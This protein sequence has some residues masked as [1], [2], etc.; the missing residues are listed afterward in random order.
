M[1]A[2]NVQFR[3][4]SHKLRFTVLA[5]VFT[6]ILG[7]AV[8]GQGRDSSRYGPFRTDPANGAPKHAYSPFA[9]IDDPPPRPL[10]PNRD[11]LPNEVVV[12]LSSDVRVAKA[13]RTTKQQITLF[14]DDTALN[15]ALERIGTE[16]IEPVFQRT[17]MA[18]KRHNVPG[19]EEGPDL[20]RW[21][22]AKC[23]VKTMEAVEILKENQA[24]KNAEPNFIRRPSGGDT[25]T[26]IDVPD[27]TAA[28][29]SVDSAAELPAEG[30]DPL[31]NKSWHLNAV[32]AP[33]AW[34]YLEG[35]GLPAG[36]SR[37]I[38]V[39][40]IDTGVDY[41][42]QDLAANLWV[43]S[44]EVPNNS[45]DDDGNGFVDDVHGVN[46]VS[47]D[48]NH[49]GDPMD[50]HGHG[51]HVAGIVAA[52]AGNG[53]GGVGVAYNTQ[54]M[55]IKAAQ[56]SG[57][58]STSDI[59]E[60]I[61]YAVAQGADIINMSFGGYGRSQIE[62]DALAVAF[63]HAVLVASAGND[64]NVN[65]PCPLGVDFYPAAYNW[66]L[67]VMASTES[68]G[69]AGFSNYDCT[70]HDAHEYELM[71]PGIDIWSTLPDN[72]YAA[73]DGTSMSAPIVSGIAALLR[74]KFD[75]KDMYSSRF[76]MGQVAANTAGGIGG[77]ADADAALTVMP[78]PEISYLRH[79]LF[80]TAE[81]SDVNDDDGIVDAGETVDLAVVIRN[82]WGKAD[83]VEVSLSAEA[84]GAVDDDPFVT[85][86][87]SAV[88]YGATGS[89]NEDDNGLIYDEG[90]A[91]TGVRH[92][93]TF[94]VSPDCPNDH[95]IPFKITM[96]CDNGYDESDPNNPYTFTSR[97]NL[98]VQR[99]K[100]LPRVISE[101][102][103]LTKDYY[104]IVAGQVLI[105]T[106]ITLTI[107]EGTQVQWG[108]PTPQDPYATSTAPVLQVEGTLLIEGTYG[109][110]VEL[111][112]SH[113]LGGRTWIRT[114]SSGT[115]KVKYT[116]IR[117]PNVGTGAGYDPASSLEH[118][119]FDWDGSCWVIASDSMTKSIVSKVQG[120]G[121]GNY[122]FQPNNMETCLLDSNHSMSLS[123]GLNKVTD[124][125]FLQDNQNNVPSSW[126]LQ[127]YEGTEELAVKNTPHKNNAFL[128]KYWDPNINHWMRF[129]LR[130][131]Q[132]RDRYFGI[133]YNYWGTTSKLLIDASI[134]DFN[135][136][137]NYPHVIYQPILT[138][139]AES[140]YPF[141]VD[142]A[143]STDGQSSMSALNG[144]TP[145]VGAEPV[146]F[147][148]TFN[149]DMDTNI[150][151]QVS[152]GPDVPETDYTV[153]P[154]DGG[155]QDPRTWAGTFNISAV[156]GDGY[157]LMRVA[158]AV[159][160]DDPWLVTGDDTERFRFEIITS[161]TEAMNL[162][163]ASAEGRVELSWFQ[164]DFDLLAGFNLYRSSQENGGYSRLNNT[165]IPAQQKSYVDRN[166][167]P[168][169]TYYYKFTVVKS[170]M[171]E[172]DFSNVA[173]GTPTDTIPPV[174]QHD[175]VTS[176]QPGL[177]L[178]LF[179]DVTDNVAVE[180]A[181]LYVRHVGETN[182]TERE[183]INTT[184]NRYV[185]TVE[186]SR[187]SSPGIE[188]YLE[189]TDGLSVAQS[190]RPENPHL[191]VVVDRPVVTAV[192]PRNGPAAGGTVV[193]VAGANFKDGATVEF[194][195]E[196]ATEVD[197]IS[198]SQISCVTPPHFP[199]TADVTVRN[200]DG[201]NGSLLR[202]YEFESDTVSLSIPETGG[203][204]NDV[205]EVPVNAANVQGLAAIDFT[206]TFDP[207]VLIGRDAK[208]GSLTADW[209][210]AVNADT[211]G[212]LRVSMA[213]GGGTVS[214]DGTLLVL[215]FEVAGEPGTNCALAI[216]TVSLNDGAIKVTSQDGSFEVAP[217]YRVS[218]NITFWNDGTPVEGV[219]LTLEG[220]RVYSGSADSS[221]D[222]VVSSAPAGAYTLT[223]AKSDEIRGISAYDASLVLQ[224][225]VGLTN[226]TGMASVAADVDKSGEINSMDAFYILQ[227]SVDLI[228]LPFPGAG[229]IWGFDPA[230]RV[231]D[232]LT[233]DRSGQ[234]FSAVLLGDVS[235]NWS[236]VDGAG[237]HSVMSTAV[238]EGQA[239]PVVVAL[240]KQAL[241]N[242][243][244]AQVWLLADASMIDL[245]SV[246]LTLEYDP[247]VKGISSVIL[248]PLDDTFTL[249]ENRGE[250]GV[251][252]VAVA[253][254][255][256]VQGNGGLLR[257]LLDKTENASLRIRDIIINEGAV[258]VEI[259]RTGEYFDGDS[260][261]DLLSDWAEIRAGTNP[262][263]AQSVFDTIGI[264]RNSDGTVTV[265]W[266]A[267][268]GNTYQ[269]CTRTR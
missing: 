109:E 125:V 254:P 111:F 27:S 219:Q 191:V 245:Y 250:P 25:S 75:D 151:P 197:V 73:W 69:R 44:L 3:F 95:V 19:E 132:P 234:A 94:T 241:D 221:G 37:D 153:H 38:V 5:L 207:E 262:D 165:V 166:V 2:L 110:P 1:K 116:R 72:Q 92:P 228:T 248:G 100:E 58:L 233:V 171:S 184:D 101:D 108:S 43:N 105:E 138:T 251:V 201:Q 188:Y 164:D 180:G 230:T 119:Y 68:G 22:R 239:A 14:S 82:H 186:G 47:D 52:Q 17:G 256:P 88:D 255:L 55:G 178:S 217:A 260:D 42:H 49:S 244:E 18:V 179:A 39:A 225:S 121:C 26:A 172:S 89:F 224:H 99:G 223:P 136:D 129:Y 264:T 85:F 124:C 170:D 157:Q 64:G 238:D 93:F 61:N 127:S 145:L 150:P 199:S 66:V 80:D 81:Q 30:S 120:Y 65:L 181:T 253:G 222:Y 112:P 198:S 204:Q 140:T 24:V 36:G 53:V 51:T 147:T 141:V 175:P 113:V 243:E 173:E 242:G 210:T 266:K 226:L 232:N 149:R 162:Q 152:F 41:N 50:N 13:G 133:A 77:V 206:V 67:G 208:S 114:R 209:S 163:A 59:A 128:S 193:T 31:L 167:D 63:G 246:D 249:A 236:A 123:Y 195:G 32:K 91:I 8:F 9:D 139:P 237:L 76:I 154:V 259:D 213:G 196:P 265:T 137:I 252:R 86:E 115:T 194:G 6:G 174:I 102:M 240:K 117:N 60:G 104:W 97:F 156:T 28:E 212:Q 187:M 205:V 176:A 211:P 160:A 87:T 183:M 185:A 62:E 258:P 263:D 98:I 169:Q 96:T 16:E 155:W 247:D 7:A 21:Y 34:A 218:G 84:E 10:L 144:P 146:T 202:A 203:A 227:K 54:I 229:V 220:N 134:Y 15:R 79:W 168:G 56:Y 46:V 142:V 4:C 48:R 261:N 182:Y 23:T 235:G 231:Y 177:A 215:E 214:G 90:G 103:T 71:A 200:P 190:G 257:V 107:N 118:I 192:S 11:Y 78:E 57:V 106:G 135:D 83:N 130:H 74:T 29:R 216:D 267:V 143:L 20:T 122:N 126:M 161:G 269:L 159:A 35:E 40:V 268:P 33:D 45:V 189:A 12:K 148:V 131:Q 158:N 70:P